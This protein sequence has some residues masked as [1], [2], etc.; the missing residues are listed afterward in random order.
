MTRTVTA[1]PTGSWL[2]DPYLLRGMLRCAGCG[3]AVLP[4]TTVGGPRRY[5]CRFGCRMVPL[6]AEAL[7][8]RVWRETCRIAPERAAAAS[9]FARAGLI[10]EVFRSITVGGG[11]TDLTYA[12]RT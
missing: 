1:L 9:R 2:T 12:R 4:L 10:G 6:S 7:E 5:A 8:E 11:V 3:D